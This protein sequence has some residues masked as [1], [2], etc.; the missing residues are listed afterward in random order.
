MAVSGHVLLPPS[1]RAG[2][3]RRQLQQER[4]H[5]GSKL[6]R[7]CGV[8]PPL[9]PG[10]SQHG[11]AWQHP[12]TAPASGRIQRGEETGPPFSCEP[13]VLL[14]RQARGRRGEAGEEERRAGGEKERKRE[15]AGTESER[16]RAE[17]DREYLEEDC[18][19]FCWYVTQTS[20]S[21]L[22]CTI[23][24]TN[25]FSALLRFLTLQ[26][27]RIWCFGDLKGFSGLH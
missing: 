24:C 1:C 12:P 8:R 9:R 23:S 11:G 22:T 25:S 27:G 15:P 2:K 4:R 17:R 6:R 14:N 3:Y 18:L 16:E 13:P 26:G 7:A 19:T 10:L 5:V 20:L 21:E